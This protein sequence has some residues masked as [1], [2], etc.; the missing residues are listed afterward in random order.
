MKFDISNEE[1]SHII[2]PAVDKFLRNYK[3]NNEGDGQQSTRKDI[4]R[5]FKEMHNL[6]K[7]SHNNCASSKSHSEWLKRSQVKD[8]NDFTVYALKYLLD[9]KI[10]KIEHLRVGFEHGHIKDYQTFEKYYQFEYINNDTTRIIPKSSHELIFSDISSDPATTF[11]MTAAHNV[12]HGVVASYDENMF[13]DP[14]DV[15]EP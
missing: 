13:K 2:K 10:F 12:T 5:I 7:G 14:T 4:N 6:I 11:D 8:I 9:N 15:D 3:T 1:L